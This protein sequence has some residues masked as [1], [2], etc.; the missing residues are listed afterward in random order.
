MR[1]TARSH[2]PRRSRRVLLAGSLLGGA[3]LLGAACGSSSGGGESSPG[4]GAASTPLATSPV[5]TL[6]LANAVKVDSLD[7]ADAAVN[8]SIWLDQNIYSRLFQPNATGTGVIN[9]LDQSYTVSKDSRTYTFH[10]RPAEFSDGTPITAADVVYSYKRAIAYPSGWGFLLTAVKTIT[11]PNPSTVVINLSEPHAPLISDLAMYGYSVLP[12]ALV[13]KEGTSFFTHPVGSGPFMVS[14]YNPNTEVD[15]TANPHFYG[16]KPKITE[17]RVEIVP[18]ANTRVLLLESGKAD[19]IENPP[20]NLVSEIDDTKKA[21]V[22]LFP[23]TQVNF[24]QLDEHFAPLKNQLVREALNYAIDRQA[25]V[26]L[27][28]QGHATPAGSFFPDGM[29][30]YDKSIQPYPYD[31]A[32]AKALLAK[33]GYPHGF[34]AFV[35]TVSGDT[36]G[37]NT[38]ILIKQELAAVGINLSIQ[39]YELTTAYAKEDGGHSELGE[40]YWTNDILDPDEVATFGA[41]STG[42]A[43]AFNSYWSDPAVN[44][45]VTEARAELVPA[46][47]QAMYD[48]IQEAVYQQSPFI[49][50]TYSPYLYGVGNWVRGFHVTP[51]GNYDLSLEDLTVSSH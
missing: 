32:K 22:D 21:T 1:S 19:I 47:R 12:E 14:S 36:P 45:L 27:A 10:L 42:G 26:K 51:L 41:D 35:I 38:A 31:P 33:A 39:S 6:V 20:A 25:I 50:T 3:A 8:E 15:L 4:T 34:S 5:K 7:P 13:K 17:V 11:A 23:S 24:L 37:Q 43:N 16:T 9:D 18:D 29:Q 44:K 40:R 30:Y 48:Q 28:Y 49:V 2:R 46:K